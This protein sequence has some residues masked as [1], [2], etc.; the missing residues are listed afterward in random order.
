MAIKHGWQ[1]DT[2]SKSD[3]VT[4]E[5]CGE[6]YRRQK[7]LGEYPTG[8]WAM[9]RGIAV[10]KAV[11]VNSAAKIENGEDLPIQTLYDAFD[12][13]WAE[14]AA[15]REE[16]VRATGYDPDKVGVE[17]GE[18]T[19]PEDLKTEGRQYV[20]IFR[21]IAA[22]RLRPTATEVNFE[23]PL[24]IEGR[25]IKL[26]GII[27]YMGHEIFSWERGE[28]AEGVAV[29]DFK[30]TDKKPKNEAW[31]SF[32]LIVYALAVE[33]ITGQLPTQ[34]GL[35]HLVNQ[36]KEVSASLDSFRPTKEHVERLKARIGAFFKSVH[37]EAFHP[38]TQTFGSWWCS[39]KF[40]GFWESC[41]LR[42]KE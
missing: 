26:R 4:F 27:D 15:K 22:P 17:P 9:V 19:R 3:L 20:K 28:T 18:E 21:E 34:V 42:P 24:E 1:I 39:P 12:T 41:K 23:V 14:E 36:K 30:T 6:K 25:K 10:H 2:V 16:K 38:A 33:S 32:E 40:C 11:E 5:M 13:S 29:L 8:S 31:K 37:A 35:V 7:L